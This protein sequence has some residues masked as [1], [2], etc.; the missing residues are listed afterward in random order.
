M[1]LEAAGCEDHRT[2]GSCEECGG[3]CVV[4]DGDAGF[5]CCA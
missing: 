5:F 4:E 3:G 1:A 2:A